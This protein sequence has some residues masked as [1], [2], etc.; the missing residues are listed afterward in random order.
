LKR[1][2]INIEN[3]LKKAYLS[4]LI[5]EFNDQFGTQ[6]LE[7]SLK[8]TI[9]CRHD[10]EEEE[11]MLQLIAQT[12]GVHLIRHPYVTVNLQWR[13]SALNLFLVSSTNSHNHFFSAASFFISD[14]LL[15]RSVFNLCHSA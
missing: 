14:I 7:T 12:L 10:F 13:A 4:C 9:S 15:A 6:C 1:G 11:T 2:F 5:K 3:G 8:E